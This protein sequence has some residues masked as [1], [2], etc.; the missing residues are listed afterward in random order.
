MIPRIEGNFVP[1]PAMIPRNLP[2]DTEKT[3]N[4]TEVLGK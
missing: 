2:N 3:G 1:N 4:D